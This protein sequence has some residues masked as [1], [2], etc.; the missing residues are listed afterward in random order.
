MSKKEKQSKKAAKGSKR[1][2]VA[3]QLEDETDTATITA[4][5]D[6]PQATPIIPETGVV[7]ESQQAETIATPLARSRL[8]TQKLRLPSILNRPCRKRPRQ[9]QPPNPIPLPAALRR[10]RTSRRVCDS[11]RS[12]VDRHGSSSPWCLVRRDI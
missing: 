8:Q 6:V 11:T 1:S 2:K 4:P 9:Y 5:A 3:A 10:R 12:R 7:A